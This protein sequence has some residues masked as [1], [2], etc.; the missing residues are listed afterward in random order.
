[1]KPMWA[2]KKKDPALRGAEGKSLVLVAVEGDRKM[3]LG[4]VRFRCVEAID[5]DTV[6]TFVRDYVEPGTKVVTDG[7][8]VYDKFQAAVLRSSPLYPPHWG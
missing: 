2:G 6:E 1:M 8:S 5:R 7:L 3:K 4:R